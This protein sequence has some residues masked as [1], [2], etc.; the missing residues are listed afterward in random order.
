[1]GVKKPFHESKPCQ[2]AGFSFIML[3]YAQNIS[4]EIAKAA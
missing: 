3:F 4:F 2:V 1:M